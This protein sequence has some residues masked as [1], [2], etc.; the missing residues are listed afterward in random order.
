MKIVETNIT[1][2]DGEIYDHQSRVL[3]IPSWED[4][5]SLFE[6]YDGDAIRDEDLRKGYKYKTLLPVNLMGII[7]PKGATINSLHF[8]DYHLMCKFT[9]CVSVIQQYKLAYLVDK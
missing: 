8:D 1:H 2:A 4:Y 3:E 6:N 7:M 5:C 9:T